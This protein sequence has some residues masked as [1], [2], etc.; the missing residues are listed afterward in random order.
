MKDA[1]R[2]GL[3]V[4]GNYDVATEYEFLDIVYYSGASYIAKKDSIGNVPEDDSEYWHIFA[5]GMG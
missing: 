1:G 3:R 5:R 4:R 2:I